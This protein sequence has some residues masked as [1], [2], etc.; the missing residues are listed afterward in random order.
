MKFNT[1]RK[2]IRQHLYEDPNAT[3]NYEGGLAFLT[4]PET[5][6]YLRSCVTLF[7]PKYYTGSGQQLQEMKALIHK[8]DPEFVLKLAYYIRTKMYIRSAPIV[9]LAEAST[10]YFENPDEEKSMV[11]EYTPRIIQRADEITELVAYWINEIGEGSKKNFPNALKKGI[12]DAMNKFDAYA[13]GKYNRKTAVTLKDVIQIVHP[14]P[15]TK[16]QSELYRKILDGE[17]ESPDTWE[18]KISTEGA[19]ADT[20]N[21]I[22]TKMGIMA[23][24]RNIRNFEKHEATQAIERVKEVLRNEEQVRNSKQLPFRWFSASKHTRD[25]VVRDLLYQAMETSVQDLERLPGKTAILVDNSGSMHMSLSQRS[26]VRYIDA[27]G[28]LSAIAHQ[29]CDESMVIPFG[30]EAR[31]IFLS[32]HDSILTKANQLINTNVGHATFAYRAFEVI[33]NSNFVPDRVI[34]LSDMQCYEE[35]G[36]GITVSVAEMWEK[37]RRENPNA[38]LYSIDMAGYGTSQVRQNEGAVLL[39]GWS[40]RVFEFVSR[41]EKGQDAVSEIYNSW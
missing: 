38:M 14:K 9:L 13:Y 40:D 7:E 11:R 4:D 2:K 18:V 29:I 23:L 1:P 3:T 12:S 34:L 19:S 15:N 26:M 20:W 5:E 17:L 10:M 35:T 32:A 24:I 28:I 37:M 22:S 39:S 25:V 27:C 31:Q 41:F 6:L 30:T 33:N 21:E 36:W 8:C 16:E